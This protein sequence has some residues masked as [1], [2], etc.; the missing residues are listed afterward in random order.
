[1]RIVLFRERKNPLEPTHPLCSIASA[2]PFNENNLL[3]QK[4]NRRHLR[5]RRRQKHLRPPLP[6]HRP[7]EPT[8]LVQLRRLGAHRPGALDRRLDH[9]RGHPR[10]QRPPRSHLGA[11]CELVHVRAQWC[12]LAV[13]ESGPVYGVEAEDGPHGR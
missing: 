1:M 12:L 13:F 2:S 11:L 5:P 3:T 9:R 4:R 8:H 10:L 6:R 7:D